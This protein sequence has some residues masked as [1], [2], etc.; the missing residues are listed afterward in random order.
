[1][2]VK[3]ARTGPATCA[4][5]PCTSCP[6]RRDVPSGVWH[7]EEYLS[8]LRY[9]ADIPGQC[10]NG[11]ASAFDCHRQTGK[12]CAGWIGAHGAEN[13]AALHLLR[14]VAPA[15]WDYKSPVRLFRS[16]AAAAKHGVR[17]IVKPGARARALIAKLTALQERRK[18]TPNS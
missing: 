13:L 11:A 18:R 8:L 3:T 17:D 12:L 6:Y 14:S 15:V 4:R 1:M 10:L 2:Q 16:G 5:T 7:A 9:D